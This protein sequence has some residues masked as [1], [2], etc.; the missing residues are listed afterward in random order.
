MMISDT[1]QM[2]GGN[3]FAVGNYTEVG[4]RA[5]KQE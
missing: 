4:K 3:A 1:S 2:H 5:A